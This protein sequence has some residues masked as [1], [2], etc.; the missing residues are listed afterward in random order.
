MS[1]NACLV[2]IRQWYLVPSTLDA[3]VVLRI[4][5]NKNHQTFYKPQRNNSVTCFF[6]YQLWFVIIEMI[7]FN[8]WIHQN[9]ERRLIFCDIIRSQTIDQSLSPSVRLTPGSR[10]STRGWPQRHLW[11]TVILRHVS[12]FQICK[13]FW[14]ILSPLCRF[15]WVR[16][17]TANWTGYQVQPD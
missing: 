14:L 6:F 13:L 5:K 11:L 4:M 10:K 16:Q 9:Q 15:N 2:S 17:W 12:K 7:G 8:D 1:P 3:M